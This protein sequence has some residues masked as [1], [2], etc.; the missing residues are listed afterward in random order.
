M[1][2]AEIKKGRVYTATV[3]IRR[4]P[5]FEVKPECERHDGRRA[6]FSAEWRLTSDDYHPSYEN[7]WAMVPLRENNEVGG[8]GVSWIA[9]GDL[10][11]IVEIDPE[12]AYAGH[13]KMEV[14]KESVLGSVALAD[15]IPTAPDFL[16]TTYR[17]LSFAEGAMRSIMML[18][19]DNVRID[20]LEVLEAARA[21]VSARRDFPYEISYLHEVLRRLEEVLKGKPNV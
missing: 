3:Q 2:E 8:W 7:E 5:G 10:I 12:Q 21:I 4:G 14:A 6:R 16:W 20:L 15:A 1:A 18:S 9:S 19:K 17:N 13:P 11:D